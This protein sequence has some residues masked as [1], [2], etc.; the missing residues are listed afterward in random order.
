M[1]T[2]EQK[3]LENT[4]TLF[5]QTLGKL[6]VKYSSPTTDRV[7]QGV[8]PSIMRLTETSPEDVSFRKEDERNSLLLIS[9]EFLVVMVTGVQDIHLVG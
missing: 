9:P 1:E 7:L 4:H 6:T 3:K 8:P 2:L 5:P